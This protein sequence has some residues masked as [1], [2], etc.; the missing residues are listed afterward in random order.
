MKSNTL[1]DKESKIAE[2]SRAKQ[3]LQK[4]EQRFRTLVENLP[5]GVYRTTPGP[6]GEFLMVNPAYLRMFGLESEQE[7]K[8][9]SAADLYA[10]PRQR[11]TYSNTLLTQGHISEFELQFKEKDGS[12]FWG[13][14]NASI[15]R[16]E[17][18]NAIYFDGII[19]DITE[20]KQAQD[21]IQT[22]RDLALK[23]GAAVRLDETLQQCLETA[24]HVAGMD[25]GGV[26]LV[27]EI[28]GELNLA[29]SQG[30]SPEFV[31]A[32]S[33]YD[34][35]S[36]NARLVMAGEPVY[37]DYQGLGLPLDDVRRRENLR[38]IAILPVHHEGKVIACLNITSHSLDKIPDAARNT[39]E[40]IAAQIG[41]F[42]ARAR[43]E[44]NLRLARR[45]WE[46]I[47]QAIGHPTLILDLQHTVIAA[48]RA[49][50]NSVGKTEAEMLGEKCY[51]IF[52]GTSGSPAG[53]PMSNLLRSA[54]FETVEMEME[55]LK[56]MFLVSCTPVF[57]DRGKLEKIIHIAT[58]ITQ[59]KRAEQALQRSESTLRS[60]FRV[61]PIGIGLVLERKLLQVNERICE[62]LGYAP[63]E[64]PGK[65]ARVLYPSDKDYEYVGREK[66]RQIRERGTGTVE[67]R[68]QRKDGT[69]IDVLLS[70]TPLDPDDITANITFT[71]LD[72]TERVRAAREIHKLNEEL[73]QRVLERTAEL[74]AANKELETFAYSVS[75][76]L[77]APLNRI[78]GFSQALAT[79]YGERLDAQGLDYL[80]RVQKNSSNMAQLIDDMLALS[81]V[82][83]RELAWTQVALSD[84]ARAITAELQQAQ[85][86]RRVK[87]VLAEGLV[88]EG[89]KNLLRLVL[90]NLLGN[91]WKFT[92]KQPRAR[93][94]FGA[95]RTNGQTIYFVQDNGAGFDTTYAHKL[96]NPF[97]RLHSPDEF[98]GTG[99]GLATVQ[100]IIRRHGGQVWATAEVN[101]GATFYFSL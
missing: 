95:T 92:S 61:A 19:E 84:L 24:I 30:L 80:Q 38:G 31:E 71:A 99:I 35:D 45:E 33:Y 97:Q 94:E 48:N 50:A 4:S 34:A 64:L 68:W 69:I 27:D 65:N 28:S 43:T 79:D 88:A 91:A 25:A 56:G 32:T 53:C 7:I 15:V 72:I 86:E 100:R 40:T 101:K 3:A 14:V 37:V 77:R 90:E 89:D 22:Q 9:M 41:S 93:I 47:F 75:H 78:N 70:S 83:R 1:S 5:V 58:D 36:P 17:S 82:T 76:D 20:R 63:G 39:L 26:Y 57:D 62:M 54:N 60:I 66:Y 87:F 55:T 12:L 6:K 44:E 8:S 11:E 98:E 23:L 13:S 51:E 73:E 52:H 49:A 42:V 2:L 96:F 81:R 10:D 85:P 29:S 67:T 59:R 46:E 16:D 18:G 74:R 21:L